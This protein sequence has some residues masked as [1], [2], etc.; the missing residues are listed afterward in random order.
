MRNKN[1]SINETTL[2]KDF[3]FILKNYYNATLNHIQLITKTRAL[4]LM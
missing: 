1:G 3:I 4:S 2:F